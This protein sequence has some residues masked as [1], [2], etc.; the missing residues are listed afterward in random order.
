MPKF[1][2]S[3]TGSGTGIADALCACAAAVEDGSFPD[4]KLHAW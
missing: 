4:D 2:R 3:F 1:V